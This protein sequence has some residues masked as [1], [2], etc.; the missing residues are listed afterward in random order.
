MFYQ[1]T[2]LIACSALFI[3]A[4][5]GVDQP[6]EE[7]FTQCL[8]DTWSHQFVVDNT[9]SAGQNIDTLDVTYTFRGDGTARLTLKKD[10]VN[11]DD[12]F[13][14]DT[15]DY[16]GGVVGGW[17]GLAELTVE[18]YANFSADGYYVT[19]GTWT[20]DEG[21]ETLTTTFSEVSGYSAW[22][23]Y[24]AA[25]DF[26]RRYPDSAVRRM[27]LV[28][29]QC[30]DGQMVYDVLRKDIDDGNIVGRWANSVAELDI[31][32][33][34]EARGAAVFKNGF[35]QQSY[36]VE[37][38]PSGYEMKGCFI[39]R[40]DNRLLVKQYPA[41]ANIFTVTDSAVSFTDLGLTKADY[42][43]IEQRGGKVYY[44]NH[45]DQLIERNPQNGQEDVLYTPA[46]IRTVVSLGQFS[47]GVYYYYNETAYDRRV[48]VR[49]DNGTTAV[50]NTLAAFSLRANSV[51]PDA[52]DGYLIQ[53]TNDLQ[54]VNLQTLES[55]RIY[56]DDRG[57]VS[58]HL[59]DYKTDSGDYYS[60][61][62]ST[63]P[64]TG[65][66]EIWLW[67]LGVVNGAVRAEREVLLEP[68]ASNNLSALDIK[69]VSDSHVLISS[70]PN[71]A[72]FDLTI[73]D[74]NSAV[75]NV[76]NLPSG[77]AAERVDFSRP[78][79]LPGRF[80]VSVQGSDDL[81]SVTSAGD[82]SILVKGSQYGKRRTTTQDGE[83]T[84]LS[85]DGIAYS[86]QDGVLNRA[87]EL[88]DQLSVNQFGW[89][90]TFN[91]SLYYSDDKNLFRIVG[92]EL[93]LLVGEKD[94][95]SD[96]IEAYPEQ[97]YFLIKTWDEKEGWEKVL[98]HEQGDYVQLL[99]TLPVYSLSSDL[100]FTGNTTSVVTL[101]TPQTACSHNSYP[102]VMKDNNLWYES[103]LAA[104]PGQVI[105]KN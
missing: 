6:T 18:S 95:L 25:K 90:F 69:G 17:A 76:I 48:F 13:R 93:Q 44:V 41:T 97:G 105:F 33:D 85:W 65:N 23:E 19:E 40:A 50:T 31:S 99:E 59:G 8:T 68:Y 36:Q 51:L 63:H 96:S 102:L 38:S 45:D 54:S 53:N 104:I 22:S 88:D 84:I 1:R 7:N 81:G 42:S 55:S 30:S 43:D 57:L 28:P 67:S 70:R 9:T 47:Q 101:H 78:G 12:I 21:A 91:N 80:Y 87:T 10:Q 82:Y 49:Y 100:K 92:S 52:F 56:S 74:R 89:I 46:K 35:Q 27:V 37:Y 2:I 4:C 39:H 3:T 71:G 86:L 73:Y 16:F 5:G 14:D 94:D 58:E 62:S 66:R 60:L 15:S 32:E 24:F 20:A 26:N 77:Y 11:W 75:K 79:S 83:R 64:Q 98:V 72:G 103:D 61:T 29:T 34:T